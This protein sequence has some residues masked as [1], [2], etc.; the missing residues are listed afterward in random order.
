[1]KLT[2]IKKTVLLITLTTIAFLFESIKLPEL[3]LE[4]IPDALRFKLENRLAVILFFMLLLVI[5][6]EQYNHLFKVSVLKDKKT[7]A[8]IF[9]VL[10]VVFLLIKATAG[11]QDPFLINIV[12]SSLCTCTHW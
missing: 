3:F 12:V 11:F 10:F 8:W 4:D 6:K 5:F 2:I 1:M 7:Y 9:S